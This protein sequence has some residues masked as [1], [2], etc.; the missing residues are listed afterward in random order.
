[1]DLKLKNHVH[2]TGSALISEKEKTIFSFNDDD[3]D[4]MMEEPI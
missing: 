4:V 3:D 1:M 2:I